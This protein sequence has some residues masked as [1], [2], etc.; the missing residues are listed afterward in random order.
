MFHFVR[1]IGNDALHHNRA[2]SS[3]AVRALTSTFELAQWFHLAFGGGRKSDLPAFKPPVATLPDDA[4]LEEREAERKAIQAQLAAQEAQGKQLLADLEAER[5]KVE[6]AELTL[7]AREK[8]E[9]SIAT[10][11]Q[12]AANVLELDELQT[13]RRYVDEALVAAGWRVE[14]NGKSNDHVGQEVPL[15]GM[16]NKSGTGY[17]DYVLWGDN[18]K[19]LAVVEVK[20]ASLEME[21]GREQAKIYADCLEKQFDVRPV[22]FYTNGIDIAVWDDAQHVP[23]RDLSGFY[24]KDSLELLHFQRQNKVPLATVTPR[25]EIAGRMYQLEAIKR[26][27]ERYTD[28]HRRALVVQATG[29]GKTRVA[30]SLCDVLLQAKWAKRILFLCDRKELRK[31]ANNVFNDFLP[32]EPRVIV[33]GKMTPIGRY[34]HE[35][36][37]GVDMKKA[38]YPSA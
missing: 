8:L 19:P 3:E 24:S 31:Q 28:G 7:K 23:P 12:A 35:L 15:E 25:H 36:W 11:G 14:S 26:V 22:I 4:A 38:A 2:N 10:A 30:I 21:K 34:D 6:A 17:A 16:P 1:K 27:C 13:R 9:Q 33:S 20:R 29:T 37:I 5:R 32:D 18:G